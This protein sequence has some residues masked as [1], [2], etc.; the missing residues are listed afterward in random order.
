MFKLS[1]FLSG[2]NERTILVKKNVVFS[3]ILQ[4]VSILCS[5]LLVPLTLN[6]LKADE[7]GVW[8]TLNSIITWFNVCEIGIG[9]GLKNKLAESLAVGDYALG[10]RYVSVT[11][12]VLTLIM[13][14]F[15]VVFLI[16][17]H[18]LDW[19]KILNIH[20]I[21]SESL[22]VVVIVVVAF[23]SIN[24]IVKTIGVILSADQ[25]ISYSS[26]MG[27]LGSL[28]SLL[29]IWVLTK[30]TS[31]SLL[32]VALVF[33]AAPVLVLIIGS[34]ILFRGRYKNIKPDWR[35]FDWE[36]AKQLVGLS[37]TFFIL[38]VSS[39]I[40]FTTSNIII[41]QTIGP[42][43]VSTYNICFKYFN[44][45]TLAFN[46]VLGPMWPAYTN[47][48][49]L[50]DMAWIS[51]GI[52]KSKQIWALLSI[53]AVIMLAISPIVYKLWI[54]NS[55]QIPFY[56]SLAMT[57]YV[58]IGNWNNIFAQMLAGVGKIRL[59]IINSL[60][61]AIIFIPLSIVLSKSMGVV[62]VTI[63]M[64]LTIFTSTIWQP[65]QSYKIIHNTARGLWN[66]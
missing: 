1:S 35:L 29:I 37:I 38:Q 60:F 56:L 23:F 27:V 18:F 36:S 31:P 22:S 10:K 49:T 12:V 58:I 40:V 6:Y 48:Y 51:N 66:K 54:G 26:L 5:F 19:C 57:I 55:V 32:N 28:L 52:R 15:V 64:T 61:N 7:Y 11:Y 43:E 24:F 62:G 16:V 14:I 53:G 63:A 42:E 30:V 59:S 25:R 20:T 50:G 65:I 47:A 8:L 33:S 9:M 44:I 21:S 39:I 2:G 3:F 13:A 34:I 45:I 17:N 41:T 46:L 4:G